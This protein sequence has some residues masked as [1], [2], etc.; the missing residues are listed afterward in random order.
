MKDLDRVKKHLGITRQDL[1]LMQVYKQF[2]VEFDNIPYAV[3]YVMDNINEEHIPNEPYI[4]ELEEED[5]DSLKPETKLETNPDKIRLKKGMLFKRCLDCGY[6]R[7]MWK[8][9]LTCANFKCKSRNIVV[10]DVD[11]YNRKIM[12]EHKQ[13][14]ESLK[15]KLDFSEGEVEYE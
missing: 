7:Q 4:E 6:E 14:K 9:Q 3:A 12:E 13:L 1:I 15:S 8:M 10:V 11:E 5:I 2:G